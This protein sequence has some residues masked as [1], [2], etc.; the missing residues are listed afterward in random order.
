MEDQPGARNLGSTYNTII[1]ECVH[2]HRHRKAFE[3]E[4]L[5]NEEAT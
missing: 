1:H 5:Y 2:W 4:R 3:L